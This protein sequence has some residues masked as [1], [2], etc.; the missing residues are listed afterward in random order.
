M[1]LIMLL[2][3]KISVLHAYWECSLK[4]LISQLNTKELTLKIVLAI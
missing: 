4:G 3:I 2:S 1:L